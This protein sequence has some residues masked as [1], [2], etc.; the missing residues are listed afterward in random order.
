[1][2]GS[3]IIWT[4]GSGMAVSESERAGILHSAS[5]L[6]SPT[7]IVDET[8]TAY[9]RRLEAADERAPMANPPLAILRHA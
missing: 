7:R 5:Y 2:S 3:L 4:D 9:R 6:N 1:V 8:G